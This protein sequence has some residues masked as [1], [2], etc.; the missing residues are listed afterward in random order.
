MEEFTKDQIFNMS[1]EEFEKHYGDL[2]NMPTDL[3]AEPEPVNSDA[4]SQDTKVDE[5]LDNAE[6]KSID[7]DFKLWK[8]SSNVITEPA[9]TEG[10]QQDNN[11]T[12]EPDEGEGTGVKQLDPSQQ[13]YEVKSYGQ[14]YNFTVDELKELA[15]KALHYIKKLQKIAPYRRTISAMEQNGV[16]ENDIN[17]FIEMK[18]GNKTAIANFL[19]NQNID[20]YDLTS[21]DSQQSANYQPLKY[22]LEDNKLTRIV[23]DLREHPRSNELDSYLKTLDRVSIE[24]IKDNPEVLEVL[25]SN[26]ENGYFDVIMPEANK[27]AFLQGNKKPLIEYYAECAEEYYSYLN[28]KDS[29]NIN[30][31]KQ[32]QQLI[33]KDARNKTRLSGKAGKE[34]NTTPRQINSA[35]DIS[36]EEFSAWEKQMGL[37]FN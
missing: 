5:P 25:M 14:K 23:E 13:V 8:N 36:E 11:T 27:R 4:E 9:N 33:R 7:K 19:S 37:N 12:S 30:K 31:Q 24:R 3:Q 20:P 6:P 2:K 17:Q 26:I 28:A 15:P 22:G 21:F 18:K 1:D 29:D 35:Y 34:L 16:S 32:Q 10:Q